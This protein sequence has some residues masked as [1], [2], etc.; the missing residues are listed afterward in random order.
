MKIILKRWMKNYRLILIILTGLILGI[1]AI[2]IGLSFFEDSLNFSKEMSNGDSPI[3]E[4]LIY[5]PSTT[6]SIEALNSLNTIL[7]NL[8]TNYQVSVGSIAYPIDRNASLSDAPSIVPILYNTNVKWKPNLIYGRYLTK[9]E[10]LSDDKIAVIGYD[11][12]ENLFHNKDIYS[13]MTINIYGEDYTV[14]GVVGRTKRYAPQN[15]QIEIPYKNYFTMYNE[16][17]DVNSIPIFI[18]GNNKFNIDIINSSELTL[19]DKP[20]YT[21]DIRIPIKL[22]FVIGILILLTTTINE[23]NLFSFWIQ[24]RRKE[25]AI[26]K[27]LG[28]TNTTIISEILTETISLSIISVLISLILQNIICIKLNNVLNNYEL[29]ITFINFIVSIVISLLISIFTSI[30]PAKIALSTNTSNELKQ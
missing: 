8:N 15:S 4:T 13:N 1:L 26:K 2:S 24:S 30:I 17:P 3:S 16:E 28:A 19:L 22:V 11:I 5:N 14:I 27:A 21:N 6:N 23:S 9:D 29:N 10:S 20:I 18:T 25:I 12:Y 7:I